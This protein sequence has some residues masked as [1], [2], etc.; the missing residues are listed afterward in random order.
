MIGVEWGS[1]NGGRGVDG[2][3]DG[4]RDNDVADRICRIGFGGIEGGG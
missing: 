1:E 2:E 3:R 4:G